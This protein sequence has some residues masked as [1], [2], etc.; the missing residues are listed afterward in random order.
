MDNTK[1]V[2]ESRQL[3]SR[4]IHVNDERVPEDAEDNIINLTVHKLHNLNKGT[5]VDCKEVYSLY[6]VTYDG[7]IDEFYVN[8]YKKEFTKF[9]D[10]RGIKK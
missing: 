9:Y 5:F 4:I 1:F 6:E 3:I 2:K 10:G 8:K 7:Y